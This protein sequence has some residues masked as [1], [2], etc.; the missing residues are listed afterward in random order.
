VLKLAAEVELNVNTLYRTLSEGQSRT[1]MPESAFL[2]AM[3]M[4]LTVRPL[5]KRAT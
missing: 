3:G 1:E 2:R 5:R 4:K